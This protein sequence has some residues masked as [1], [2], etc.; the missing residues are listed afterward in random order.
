MTKYSN[1][2]TS[3]ASGLISNDS[4]FRV[5]VEQR[6]MD[7]KV[8]ST[9]RVDEMLIRDLKKSVSVCKLSGRKQFQQCLLIFAISQDDYETKKDIIMTHRSENGEKVLVRIPKNHIPGQ[10]E[11]ND[12]VREEIN[13]C[14]S[15]K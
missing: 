4:S 5:I 14:T 9:Y 2:V 13:K 12:L 3:L 11:Y 8:I 7:A 10:S 6:I 1:L 15:K